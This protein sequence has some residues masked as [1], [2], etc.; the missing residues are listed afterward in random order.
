MSIS[1]EQ[2]Q[3]ARGERAQYSLS[4]EEMDSLTARLIAERSSESSEAVVCYAVDTDSP[5]A[6]LARSLEREIFEQYFGNDAE[7]MAKEY[8]PYEAQSRFFLS[9]DQTTKAPV[10]VL[11]VIENGPAGL[12]TINDLEA[13]D[14][15]DTPNLT[16]EQVSQ[17]HNIESYDES[18]DVGTVA[19]RKEYRTKDTEASVQLYRALYVSAM[20]ND[21]KHFVSIIDARPL[22]KMVDYLGIPFVPMANSKSFSYLGSDESQAVYGHVPEFYD[23][24]RRGRLTSVK[25]LMARKA[26]N[27]LVMGKMDHNIYL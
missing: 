6:A 21:I 1:S 5:Y 17:A 9:V 24:M 25:R 3:P 8:G 15:E 23:T 10:G 13:M 27:Q 20:E 2:Q 4:L 19:V 16:A 11:R 22:K 18:W 7:E 12:K 14:G 26:F